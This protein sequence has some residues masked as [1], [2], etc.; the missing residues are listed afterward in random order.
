MNGIMEYVSNF[1]FFDIGLTSMNLFSIMVG[2]VIA[3][4]Q[5]GVF[6]QKIGKYIILYL[7][8][9]VAWYAGSLYLERNLKASTATTQTVR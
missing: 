6:G 1:S 9:L 2:M 4:F 3:F 7:V 8:C 5:Q